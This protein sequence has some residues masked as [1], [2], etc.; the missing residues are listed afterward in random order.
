MNF[1]NIKILVTLFEQFFSIQKFT[2]KCLIKSFSQ[3]IAGA[4]YSNKS[5]LN[6]YQSQ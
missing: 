4:N 1:K 5:R 6:H 3:G 2:E